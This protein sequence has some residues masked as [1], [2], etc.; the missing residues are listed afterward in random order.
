MGAT[1][2]GVS[3]TDCEISGVGATS[4]EGC[5]GTLSSGAGA[6]ST[7]WGSG[8]G[9]GVGA[10][11]GSGTGVEGDSG[12]AGADKAVAGSVAGA[13]GRTATG[14]VGAAGCCGGCATGCGSCTNSRMDGP[15]F[16][17]ASGG[18]KVAADVTGAVGPMFTAAAT[19][20]AAALLL[21]SLP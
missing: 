10:E 3:G 5:A 21:T 6:D 18:M 19:G 14:P 7:D 17:I 1:T 13:V 20:C 2:G 15:G 11:A 12:V 16:T 8:T 9:S 4:R